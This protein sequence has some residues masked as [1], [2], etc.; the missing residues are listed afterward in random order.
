MS[1]ELFLEIGT[2]E[3]P[4]AFLPGARKD[5]ERLFR[6]ELENARVTFGPIRTFATP[7]RLAVA[8]AD[9]A[10][11]QEQQELSVS[12]PPAKIAY[13]ADGNPTKAAI[14]FAKT[15]G[16]DISDLQRKETSKGTYLYIHKVVEG[17]PVAA[18]L[19]EMLPCILTAI[20][21][22]KSMRWKDFDLRFAR[23]V[24][25]LVALFNGQVVPFRFGHLESGNL[26]RGHRFMA[27]ET[28]P[29]TGMENY[30]AEAEK[31]FVIPEPEKRKEIIAAEIK[32]I[33]GRLGGVLNLDE[34][35]L[36]EVAHLVEYP[37]PICG[38]FEEKYLELPVEL[39]V[40]TMKEHQR[41]F[42]VSAPDGSLL[43]HF[44]TVANTRPEDPEVVRRGNER[45]LRARLADAMFFWK[46]DRK[47]P[48]AK[49]LDSLKNVVFQAK[50]GTSYEKVMRFRELAISLARQFAPDSTESV[51]RAALLAKCDLETQMVGEFPELQGIMGREY[52]LLQGEPPEVAT[53]IYEHYLPVQAGGDLP[54]GPIGSILSIADKIDTICGCFG[55]GLIPTGTTDPFALRRSAIG[56]LH[57][58]LENG[59]PVPL[60]DLVEHSLTLLKDKLTRPR[61]ETA[62]EVIEFI[63]QRFFHILTSRGFAQDVVSAVLSAAFDEPGDALR[64]VEA[65]AVIRK[66]EDFE[67]L[68][69]AFKRVMNI[70]KGG[71]PNQVDPALFT[72]DA[73]KELDRAVAVTAA[74]V[75][76]LRRQGKY[77]EALE[78]MAHLRGPV[79]RFFEDVLVMDNDPKIRTNRLALLTAT[80]GLF[81]GIAD[82]SR[83]AD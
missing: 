3:I 5:L 65:L 75:E 46:E 57:I 79:D 19:P 32:K 64:R 52:A 25:W 2:E 7:R 9:V 16:V 60:R 55:V 40:T 1:T 31:R 81:A 36:N 70:I 21:F 77:Q 43:P 59:L 63:R 29:V 39:L 82:F 34:E 27:P 35:L 8:I 10:L 78:S 4:A 61:D 22:K 17:R 72:V 42:T 69:V 33:A 49:R 14:G 80:A 51:D 47:T 23:P 66:K 24:H 74:A 53:A 11:E 54:S 48:L 67:P 68:A 28:F 30:L 18:L 38:S 50:L 44:I 83:I 45:V 71:V 12:G 15:N 62:G 37:S 41:Y 58:V 73:E 56:I 26:S 20:P 13:D 6:K 76:P